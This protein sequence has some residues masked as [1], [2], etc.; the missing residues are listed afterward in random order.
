MWLNRLII[1]D[2]QCY[3]PDWT[4]DGVAKSIRIKVLSEGKCLAHIH[5]YHTIL[6][7][8]KGIKK[9]FDNIRK[10]IDRISTQKV[11]EMKLKVDLTDIK[12]ELDYSRVSYVCK[13]RVV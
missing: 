11:S 6:I 2:T 3:I 9:R 4:K 7:C 13:G 8:V 1:S 12:K 5:A 10:K